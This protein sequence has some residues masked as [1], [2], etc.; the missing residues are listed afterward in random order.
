V[1]ERLLALLLLEALRRILGS[2]YATIASAGRAPRRG[3]QA[4][5]APLA[6]VAVLGLVAT[7][8]VTTSMIATAGP[9]KT[10]SLVVA[11]CGTASNG[12]AT[13]QLDALNSAAPVRAVPAVPAATVIPTVGGVSPASGPAAGGTTVTIAGIGFTG[14]TA[15][16]FGSAPALGFTVNSD[17]GITATAPPGAPGTVGVTVTAPAGTSATSNADRYQ[18]GSCHISETEKETAMPLYMDIHTIPG[19]ILATSTH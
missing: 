12:Q 9:T 6:L 19:G 3:R 10:S 4:L 17:T 13:S 7:A 1:P 16:D 11:S 2:A 14:A 8:G 15:V 5:V 18:Y